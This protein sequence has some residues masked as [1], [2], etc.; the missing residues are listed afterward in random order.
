VTVDLAA[1]LEGNV[2]VAVGSLPITFADF[3]VRAPTAPI[4]ASVEDRGVME[5]QLYFTK[6]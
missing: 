1:Q 4:V 6:R 3:G 5:F 2:L